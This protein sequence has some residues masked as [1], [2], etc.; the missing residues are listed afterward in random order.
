ML[1]FQYRSDAMKFQDVLPKRL[2][3]FSLS[4]EQ[5]KTKLIEFGSWAQ[6]K[7]Q[8]KGHAVETFCFL[9]FSFYCSKNRHGRFKLGTKTEKSRLQRSCEKMKET[10]RKCRHLKLQEQAKAINIRLRGHYQYFGIAGNFQSMDGFYNVTV[11]YWRK[12]LSS[13]SQNGNVNWT[14][15]NRILKI[16]HLCQPKLKI[17]YN[18][19]CKYVML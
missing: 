10:L 15:F 7:A 17:S 8:S 4:L 18:N 9:G 2:Q 1:C 12:M 13:R 16:F 3:R 14:K 11:R 5:S 19:I 6:R